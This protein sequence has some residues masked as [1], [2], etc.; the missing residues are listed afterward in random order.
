MVLYSVFCLFV[1]GV[2]QSQQNKTLPYVGVTQ[3]TKNIEKKPQKMQKKNQTI[4]A[5]LNLF[6]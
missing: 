6:I 5:N 3:G 1:K 2:Y 4:I